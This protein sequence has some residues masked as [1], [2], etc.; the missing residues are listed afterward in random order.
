MNEAD[1]CRTYVLPKLIEAG[2]DTPPHSLTEQRTFTDSRIIPVGTSI[3]RGKQKRADYLL[4]YT[5]D[6]PLAVVEAKAD[7]K[8]PADGMQQAKEYAEILGLKFAYTT[9]G[10]GIAEFDF[11]TGIE[12]IL[13]AFP[14]PS[15]LWQRLQSNQGLTGEQAEQLLTPY[16]LQAGKTP[17]YYQDIAIHRAVQTIVQGKPRVLLTMAT[18]TGKTTTAFQICWKLWAARWNRAGGYRRPKIL[19][20]ADRNILVDDPMIKD[21]APFGDAAHKIAHGEAIKSRD[22]YFAI[23]QAIAQDERRPGLYREYAP[24][25]PFTG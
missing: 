5:R 19:Y 22:L 2:W 15:A 14:S 3:R 18:G 12:A 16:N 1:T 8:S 25:Y 23:Y 13:T 4:R 11:I 6:F 7:Y 24:E 9:N 21:F 10:H 20:L 17:R